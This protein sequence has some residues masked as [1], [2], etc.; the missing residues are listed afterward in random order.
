MNK[1]LFSMVCAGLAC[2][3]SHAAEVSGVSLPDATKVA[4]QAL[5]LNGAGLRAMAVFRVYVIGMYLPQRSSSVPTVLDM[6]GPKRLQMVLMRD[7][8]GEDL[9]RALGRGIADNNSAQ[10]MLVL[11]S[12][13]D[14]LKQAMTNKGETPKGSQ[15]LLDYAPA[16]GTHI[17]INGKALL[18]DIPGE[19]F[20]KAL[21]RI[22]LGPRPA[23]DYLKQELLGHSG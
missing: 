5:V 12:R 23:G 9:G 16:T 14:Q 2:S 22:W 13:V 15:V 19:D 20:Y 8:E 1:L 17:T 4:D 21:L 18:T 10:E 3:G 11:Q 7:V 6:P